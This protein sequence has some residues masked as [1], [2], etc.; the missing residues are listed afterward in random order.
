MRNRESN[1][2][3]GE[4]RFAYDVSEVAREDRAKVPAGGLVS[5]F[6]SS[7]ARL[8]PGVGGVAR[9]QS[10]LESRSR[11]RSAGRC[12]KVGADGL[13]LLP[14][15]GGGPRAAPAPWVAGGLEDT[16]V[17][18]EHVQTPQL[19]VWAGCGD[20]LSTQELGKGCEG[21]SRS[22]TQP[23]VFTVEAE[24]GI[25]GAPGKGPGVSRD[26]SQ[27]PLGRGSGGSGRGPGAVGREPRGLRG[28]FL[29]TLRMGPGVSR[30]GSWGF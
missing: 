4:G 25:Q 15:W 11:W 14:G 18:A 28:G 9:R 3:F 17:G 21:R 30:E 20:S 2:K 22:G 29:G 12:Q 7:G 16:A 19:Q 6:G 27:G 5:V 10:V 26:E 8:R 13:T 23:S 1:S 24:E